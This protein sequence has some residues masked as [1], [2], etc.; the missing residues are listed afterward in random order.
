[1]ILAMFIGT[2]TSAWYQVAIETV[3]S[4]IL[5]KDNHTIIDLVLRFVKDF[6]KSKINLYSY[7]KCKNIHRSPWTLFS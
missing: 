3:P 4:T 7:K 2:F 6:T 5:L 1:M